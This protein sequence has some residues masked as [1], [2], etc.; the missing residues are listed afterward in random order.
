MQKRPSSKVIDL[1]RERDASPPRKTAKFQVAPR[2]QKQISVTDDSPKWKLH[3][4]AH[5]WAKVENVLSLNECDEY[6]SEFW[7]WLEA[8]N[9]QIKRDNPETWT[10]KNWPL[11]SHGLVQHYRFGHAEFVWKIRSTP[12]IL[13]IFAEIYQ[14]EPED[15]IVSF[16]G[17]KASRPVKETK[18]QEG[19]QHLDQGYRKSDRNPS[20]FKVVQ[21]YV[22]LT[23]CNGG[24]MVYDNSHLYHHEFGKHFKKVTKDNWVMLTDEEKAWYLSRGCTEQMIS[25]KAGGLGLWDSRAV[26]WAEEPSDG[27]RFGVFVSFMRKS[28]ATEKALARRLEIFNDRRMTTHWA[29][30]PK[31]FGMAPR[32]YGNPKLEAKIKDCKTIK[33]KKLT[34]AMKSLI[35]FK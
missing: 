31:L 32:T 19:W 16:D 21:G 9:P 34:P 29:A 28:D 4:A 12:T 5:G 8:Y 23:N 22:A 20:S 17:G 33:N 3:L 1:T 14:C 7:S 10:S 35:P 26:H 18:V 25:L 30:F 13:K 6:L 2:D 11:G 27:P 15:L 24:T